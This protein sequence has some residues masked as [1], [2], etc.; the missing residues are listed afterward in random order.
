MR[1]TTRLLF[2]V[3]A[4]MFAGASIA[5]LDKVESV[6]EL[7]YR[8][9]VLPDNEAG[10][11]VVKKCKKCA[12]LTLPVNQNTVYRVGAFDAPVT[13]LQQLKAAVRQNRAK[14]KMIIYVGYA[15]DTNVVTR[16]IVVGK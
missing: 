16:L 10:R 5:A 9:V 2:M 4:L 15:P 14:N 3:A 12:E 11:V 7:S 13:T 6:L 1:S 8:E